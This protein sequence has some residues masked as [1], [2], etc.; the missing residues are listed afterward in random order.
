MHNVPKRSDTLRIL[1]SSKYCEIFKL[2][3]TILGYYKKGLSMFCFSHFWKS[4]LYS[5]NI[6][7]TKKVK[8]SKTYRWVPKRSVDFWQK[9]LNVDRIWCLQW[10][11]YIYCEI[12]VI[13]QWVHFILFGWALLLIF[14]LWYRKGDLISWWK[15]HHN[16]CNLSSLF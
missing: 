3:L 6:Y 8:S 9:T 12:C 16:N 7:Q 10:E 4:R 5:I 2:C 15:W 1:H 11:N 14:E 13:L